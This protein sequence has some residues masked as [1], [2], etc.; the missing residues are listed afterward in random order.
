[1]IIVLDLIQI[2]VIY[3]M[4]PIHI[5]YLTHVSTTTSWKGITL[6][7]KGKGLPSQS[8]LKNTYFF[9]YGPC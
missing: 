4:K 6:Y 3:N 1:M 2:I 8:T 9:C 7:K 5:F